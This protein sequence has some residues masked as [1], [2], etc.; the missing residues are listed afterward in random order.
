MTKLTL[1][2]FGS[3][4][5][6]GLPACLD[7]ITH[8]HNPE[9]IKWQGMKKDSAQGVVSAKVPLQSS[10]KSVIQFCKK[11]GLSPSKLTQNKQGFF[12]S[13]SSPIVSDQ[14][15][16]QAKWLLKFHFDQSLCLT[17]TDIYKSLIR[18]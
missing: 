18:F 6:L 16:A 9:L 17:K 1:Y 7:P 8:R 2:I 10:P 4:L 13:A 14:V 12:I 5:L 11:Q 15:M 3:I